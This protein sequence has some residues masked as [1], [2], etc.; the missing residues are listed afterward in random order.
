MT[1]YRKPDK[2]NAGHHKVGSSR[3][4]DPVPHITSTRPTQG[5]QDPVAP[6]G[7]SQPPGAA[8]AAYN[9]QHG[10]ARQGNTTQQQGGDLARAEDVPFLGG[11]ILPNNS[12]NNLSTSP[13][14]LSP[15]SSVVSLPN[16]SSQQGP[17]V[18]PPN[19]D[20]DECYAWFLTVDQDGNGQLS[21]DEL[22]SALLNEGGLSFSASTVKY[23]MGIFDLDGN[24]TIGFE[25]F[26]P[27]WCFMTQWRQLFDSFDID[28]DG[29]IDA[30]ELGQALAHY[31][32]HVGQ[33]ILDMLVNK[34]GIT[35][36][37]NQR[38]GYPH[39]LQMDLDHFVCACVVVRQMCELYDKCTVGGPK[40]GK[41]QISRDRFLETVILLP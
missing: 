36:P 19:V 41:S 26:E 35:A 34:Y 29:R 3:P 11:F 1:S 15:S 40:P 33:S 22:R 8:R 38:P 14:A 30:A 23:L 20:K 4:V 12:N 13:N 24:G 25:E 2:R 32:L 39:R 31:N 27:L 10:L 21:P 5:V 17:P 28:R 6:S 7:W 37:W 9:P 18:A 16:G